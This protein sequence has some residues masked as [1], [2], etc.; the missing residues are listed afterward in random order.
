MNPDNLTQL[1]QKG[2]RVTLG[3]TSFF[4]ETVQ[5]SSK[6]DENLN[7]LSTDFN[8][9]TEE[10]ADRGEMTE[11]EARNFVDTI[12]NQQNSQVN[13]DSTTASSSPT[14]TS[15]FVSSDVQED[16][17]ELTQEIA[18]LRADLHKLQESNSQN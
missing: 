3:A 18:G 1:L 11:Q 4:I 16:L 12:L 9:L 7:K 15:G 6:R 13:T 5:D 17:L 10:W 8:Q 2:F 14:S